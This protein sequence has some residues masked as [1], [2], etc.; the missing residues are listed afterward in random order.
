MAGETGSGGAGGMGA[1][2]GGMGGDGGR[3]RGGG[4]FDDLAGVAGGAFSVLAG[5]RQEVE[6]MARSQVDA[7]V[8]RLELVRREE[9]DAA[10]EVARRAR[11]GQEALEARVA[12]L[13]ARLAGGTSA[14]AAAAGPPDTGGVAGG[15]DSAA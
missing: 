14:T 3:R 12:A 4:L 1:G 6:A 9:L 8:Q 10:L 2:G 5:L 7:M 11:E 13:E 15:T